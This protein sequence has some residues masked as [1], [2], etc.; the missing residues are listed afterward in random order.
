MGDE[1][2]PIS[3][4]GATATEAADVEAIVSGLPLFGEAG[5]TESAT[6]AASSSTEETGKWDS[7]K[8]KTGA[9]PEAKKVE[10]YSKEQLDKFTLKDFENPSFDWSKVPPE[11]A[12][13]VK[14]AIATITPERQRLAA[15]KREL[16]KA[17]NQ[18]PPQPTETPKED[19]VEAQNRQIVESKLK[20]LGVPV[21]VLKGVAEDVIFN[22]GMSIA[23]QHVP[24]YFQDPKFEEAVN[25][26]IVEDEILAT[27]ADSKNPNSIAHAIRTAADRVQVKTLTEKVTT[28]EKRESDLVAR[29]KAVG[30]KEA[31][32]EKERTKLNRQKPTMAGGT[33]RGSAPAAKSDF[34]S[35]EEITKDL[36][37]KLRVG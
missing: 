28:L 3:G 26:V 23:A 8:S 16:A 35:M 21:E 24:Q 29:E 22:K 1:A 7:G 19:D 25:G 4:G 36:P 9:A 17:R 34:P 33:S 27:L 30:E 12:D 31:E 6:P 13:A 18:K 37:D 32:I 10:L 14:A 20:E 2:T 15:E 5:A 11:R